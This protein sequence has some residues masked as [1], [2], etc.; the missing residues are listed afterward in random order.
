MRKTRVILSMEHRER[1][2]QNRK[3]PVSMYEQLND[4]NLIICTFIKNKESIL[5]NL[6][7]EFLPQIYYSCKKLF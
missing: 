3:L 2:F 5:L 1:H 7:H 4:L 6:Q